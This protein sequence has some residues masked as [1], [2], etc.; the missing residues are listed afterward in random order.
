MRLKIR[1]AVSSTNA[2]AIS[3]RCPLCRQIGTFDPI[4]ADYTFTSKDTSVPV[5]VGHRRCPNPE[6][7]AHVFVVLGIRAILQASYPAER[8][9]FNAENIPAEI[10]ASIE[11][12]ITCRANQ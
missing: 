2:G 12:A 11:E 3:L 9:D 10:V 6:C 4:G 5:A 7:E 8:I 1:G